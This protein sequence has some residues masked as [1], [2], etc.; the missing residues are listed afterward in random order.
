MMM[1]MMM[2]VLPSDRHS[3]GVVGQNGVLGDIWRIHGRGMTR[4]EHQ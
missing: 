2:S 4:Y 3:L 1:M